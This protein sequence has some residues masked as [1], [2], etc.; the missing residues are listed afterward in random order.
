MPGEDSRIEDEVLDVYVLREGGWRNPDHGDVAIP[1]AWA[2]LPAGDAY[3]TR[4]VVAAGSH[5][6]AWRPGDRRGRRRRRLGVWAPAEHIEVAEH[7]AERTATS[8]AQARERAAEQRH[9]T[10]RTYRDELVT[11]IVAW[12][13]FEGQ[14]ADLA[15][16]IARAAAERA[17][18]VGS[19]RV[20]RTSTLTIE[21]KAALAARAH[22]R[23]HFTDY[24]DQLLH[25]EAEFDVADVDA[26]TYRRL[27]RQAHDAVDRFLAEHRPST[28][29][30]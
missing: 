8:R 24:E 23:H 4:T 2:F 11:A 9:E 6:I 18:A 13:D 3:L 22:I 30:H 7:E 19:G 10:E 21:E 25:A 1:D 29:A 28:D 17:A 5:W 27:R 20:G 12:L 14:H 15:K 16:Q 26:D